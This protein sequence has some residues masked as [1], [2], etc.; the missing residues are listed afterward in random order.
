ME[1]FFK[2]IKDETDKK[3][4]ANNNNNSQNN[5]NQSGGSSWTGGNNLNDNNNNSKKDR[6]TPKPL[7]ASMKNPFENKNLFAGLGKSKK[8]QGGGQSLGGTKPGKVIHVVIEDPGPIG[9]KVEKRSKHQQ[10]AIVAMVV[11]GSQAEAA[12]IQRGDIVCHPGSNGQEEIMYD[13]F[14]AMAASDRRPF[15]FDVRRVEGGGVV[16]ANESAVSEAA[17]AR[18][19]GGTK[20]GGKNKS[21]SSAEAYARKQAVI[22]AAEKRDRAHK[23]KTKPAPKKKN[24]DRLP[25][26][27]DDEKRTSNDEVSNEPMSEEARKA[28]ED[29]K[30]YEALHAAQLGY[31]PYETARMGAGQARTATTTVT[32]GTIN[33]GAEGGNTGTPAPNT[34]S[35][36]SNPVQPSDVDAPIDPAFDEAFFNH[37][38]IFHISVHDHFQFFDN[39]KAHN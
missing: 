19:G 13:Q 38:V 36:P 7:P 5:K 27:G 22:A 32:H 9:V 4:G 25:A 8:F 33:A 14:V 1:G 3:F 28:V 11:S 10:T 39:A 20:T 26:K 18:A 31:N 30:N 21:I 29:S 6:P 2:K 23:A 35:P 34:V 15:I 16:G 17:A 24:V 12:K 37:S